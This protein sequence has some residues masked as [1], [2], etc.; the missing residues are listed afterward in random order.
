MDPSHHSIQYHLARAL[1]SLM[2]L[3][4]LASVLPSF[5]IPSGWGPNPAIPRHHGQSSARHLHT[6]VPLPT[7]S[8]PPPSLAS[9]GGLPS[10]FVTNPEPH[11]RAISYR[12]S[13]HAENSTN[14]ATSIVP[15]SLH[16]MTSTS[17]RNVILATTV[18]LHVQN[19]HLGPPLLAQLCTLKIFQIMILQPSVLL[20]DLE[21]PP[22]LNRSTALAPLLVMELLHMLD[23]PDLSSRTR[24]VPLQPLIT[25]P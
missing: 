9:H 25:F 8:R 13:R 12:D 10:Q 4:Q 15:L 23:P 11:F 7:D 2:H 24:K 21:L 14:R 22:W 20:K 18:Q 1:I 6:F 16:T 19:K 3:N 5:E 17:M